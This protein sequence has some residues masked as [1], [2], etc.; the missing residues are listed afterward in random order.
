MAGPGA[1][2]E[3]NPEYAALANP[4]YIGLMESDFTDASGLLAVDPDRLGNDILPAL[5]TAGETDLPTVEEL[6]DPSF[7]EEARALVP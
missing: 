7:L 6:F 2:A 3:I 5:E 1:D 4:A